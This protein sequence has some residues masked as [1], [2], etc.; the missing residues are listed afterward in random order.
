MSESLGNGSQLPP[1]RISIWIGMLIIYVVWSSTYLA[2]RFAVESFPPFIMA[3]ARFLIAGIILYGFR[4][5]KGDAPPR[6]LEW[7][8]TAIIGL[9]LLLGGN[10]GVSWAEQRVVSSIAALIVGSTPLWIVLVDAIRPNGKKPGWLAFAGVILGFVGIAIL[11]DPWGNNLGD[12]PIA[13]DGWGIA[14]LLL[15]SLSWAIGSV[16][17]RQA[18]IPA[19][20]LLATG[21]EMIAGGIGLLVV[22]TVLGEWQQLRLEEI[23]IR[24]WWSLAYLII[25]GSLMGF[26]TYTWLLRVAPIS[27]VS[28]YAYVNP[29]VAIFLGNVLAQEPLTTQLVISAG[30]IIGSV[31]IITTANIRQSIRNRRI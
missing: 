1:T 15:A 13:I 28:T 3:A 14:A 6:R 22:G 29:L 31:I 19:S 26:A 24:S 8:S 5:I 27:L 7:R 25:F 16:F 17:S 18:E 2:I 21:M 4:R 30:I 12:N 11:I 9:F 20:P 23:S 10:G